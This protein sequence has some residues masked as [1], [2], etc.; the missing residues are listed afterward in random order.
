MSIKPI[1]IVNFKVYRE[2]S[3]KRAVQLARVCEKV[4]QES[5]AA[6][7]VAPALVDLAGVARSVKI[8]VFAQHLDAAEPG[9]FTGHVTAE[10]LQSLGVQ[11]S[12]INHSEKPLSLKAIKQTAAHCRRRG[13]ISI[14]CVA[15]LAMV[16]A[17]ARFHPDYI[18]YEPPELIGGNISVTSA[19]PSVVKKAVELIKKISPRT[20]P[21]CGAG[22]KNNLDFRTALLLGTK[23]VLLASGVVKAKNQKKALRELV[24][25]R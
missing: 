16:K 1:V 22:V 13:L 11:G 20:V 7:A 17:V 12:L 2:S 24:R 4:S 10:S 14:V 23:G 8:P 21:I 6:I 5:G 9:A 18:A 25:V 3:G 19:K 15:N